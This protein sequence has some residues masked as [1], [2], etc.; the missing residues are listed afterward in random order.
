MPKNYRNKNGK[1]KS[2]FVKI[3]RY[4]MR[5]D[6]WKDL[7]PAD[8]AVY[9][10][11]LFRYIGT[12]NGKIPLSVREAAAE[13]NIATETARKAFVRLE[14]KGFIINRY[15]GSFSQKQKRASEWE[16][17]HVSY[18]GQLPQKTFTKYKKV[19]KIKTSQKS[20][21]DCEMENNNVL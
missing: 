19:E 16:L 20:G 21:L 15:K 18:K 14:E 4:I 10:I 5:T 3:D 8:K 6:A 12:N 7:K 11:L 17:T 13:A 9:L 2:S 1:S